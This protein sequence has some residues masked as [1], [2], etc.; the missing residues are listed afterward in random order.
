M[1]HQEIEIEFKNILTFEEFTALCSS[2]QVH[3]ED[4]FSQENHYFD[5]EKFE[6]KECGCALRIR[7]KGNTYTLTLKQPANEGL[8]ETHQSITEDEKAGMFD[9]GLGLIPGVIADILKDELGIEA[10]NIRYFGSLKTNRVEIPYKGGLLVLDESHY[11]QTSDFEMEYEVSNYQEGQQFF[12]D[13]LREHHIPIRETKNKIA[14]FYD[15]K[16]C[17]LNE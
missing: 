5:T 14:R 13:L 16:V 4:F 9:E 12:Y 1:S 7:K 2:F 15:V 3:S 8:L 10:S 17:R 6:L 11:L